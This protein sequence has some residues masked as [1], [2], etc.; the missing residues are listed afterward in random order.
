MMVAAA[1][2][3]MT[4]LSFKWIKWSSYPLIGIMMAFSAVLILFPLIPDIPVSGWVFVPAG[5]ILAAGTLFLVINFRN[6][7][8]FHGW[9]SGVVTTFILVELT[10]SML[11]FPAFNPI[12]TP[13]ALAKD[14][15]AL[16]VP[17][18]R[19]L[20]YDMNG[21][22]MALYSHRKGK[23]IKDPAE[24][25]KEIRA[26]GKGIVVFSEEDWDKIK[27]RFKCMGILHTFE[28][29]SK[30]LCYLV[31]DVDTKGKEN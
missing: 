4:R 9:F 5:V 25:E 11:I 30:D 24:L 10:V 3:L 23:H 21:E 8:L 13:Q 19:L 1:W 6:N 7:G 22:I 17:D 20:L 16:L 2:P 27:D 28:M 31:Y 18:K 29:G 26:S 15:E 12:K 14:A